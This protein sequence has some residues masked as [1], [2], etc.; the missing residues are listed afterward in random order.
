MPPIRG[1]ALTSFPRLVTELGGDSRVLAAAAGIPHEDIGS[2][3]RYISLTAGCRLLDT[4]AI[5]LGV[6]DLGRRLARYQGIG[7][8]GVLGTAARSAGTVAEAF[9]VFEKFMAEYS[10]AIS[11]RMIPDADPEF[12]RFEFE[13]V[14]SAPPRD[15]QAIELSLGVALAVLR[16]FLGE[17]YRPVVVHL[18]HRALTPPVD[19]RTYYGCQPS[20]DE[21]V[22]AFRVRS[23]DLGKP[24][25]ADQEAHRVAIDH[26]LESVGEH[27]TPL[28]LVVRSEVRYALPTGPVGLTDIAARL[29][30]HPK[31]LQRRLAAEGTT[32]GELVHRVRRDTAHRLLADTDLGLESVSLRLGYAEQSVLTRSCWR[33]FE[34]TPAEY[35][36]THASPR[37]G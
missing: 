34:A 6:P 8:L 16:L 12:H 20:F 21:P 4:A 28:S 25:T 9:D 23:T 7:I 13:Y 36:R 26:L 18:P 3:D 11:A 19:Y 15:A 24:L 17:G 1:S 2:P 30:V 31:A 32:F 5:Q 14:P 10:P 35:R 27:T 37:P 33:W 22:A 29:D